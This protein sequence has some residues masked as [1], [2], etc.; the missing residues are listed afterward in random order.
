MTE[1]RTSYTDL[2]SKVEQLSLGLLSIDGKQKQLE[3]SFV[4]L[5]AI[6]RVKLEEDKAVME[7]INSL[8]KEFIVEVTCLDNQ[9]KIL[10]AK[11][12]LD[13]LAIMKITLT[14]IV[15]YEVLRITFTKLL[16]YFWG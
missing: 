8:L 15:A 3:T 4:D 9:V 14:S 12:N 6:V 5:K 7:K 10:N 16:Q 11:N 2:N 1:K 13:R